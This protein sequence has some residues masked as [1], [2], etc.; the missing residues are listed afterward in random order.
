MI[1]AFIL[2]FT[3]A[4]AS[5]WLVIST[6][7]G[8]CRTRWSQVV[9]TVLL[10]AG[11]MLTMCIRMVQPQAVGTHVAAVGVVAMI[12]GA[13][14]LL[15]AFSSSWIGTV[16]DQLLIALIVGVSVRLALAWTGADRIGPEVGAEVMIATGVLWTALMLRHQGL[17]WRGSSPSLSL[18]IRAWGWIMLA[19]EAMLLL[20][21][22]T[23]APIVLN[24][25]QATLVA[26]SVT[27]TVAAIRYRISSE[28]Q[29]RKVQTA[30]ARPR[31]L[32]YWLGLPTAT[33]VL[34]TS[35]TE[36]SLIEDTTW[37]LL[38]L[39]LAA[40]LVRQVVA[41][42]DY[43]ELTG[44]LEHQKAHFKSLVQNSTD[45]IIMADRHT[46]AAVYVSPAASTILGREASTLVG[47]PLHELTGTALEEMR[48]ALNALVDEDSSVHCHGHVAG[49][50][51]ETVFSLSDNNVLATVRDVTERDQL[52]GELH[53]L[54]YV[55][56]LTGLANRHGFM[57]TL[58]EWLSNP[59]YDVSLLFVDLDRFKQVNDTGGHD[60]GDLV[61]KDVANR[62]RD[63]GGHNVTW[64][65][66]GGDEFVA[67]VIKPAPEADVEDLGPLNLGETDLPEELLGPE[68]KPGPLSA[69][70]VEML[71]APFDLGDRQ[72]QLG[73]S[74]GVA[75]AERGMPATELVRQA[76]IA[77]YAAKR[78]KTA[79]AVYEPS[80][81]AQLHPEA[82]HDVMVAR[83]LRD[84]RFVLYGQPI[85]SLLSN[86]LVNVEGLLRWIDTSGKHRPPMDIL[87]FADRTGQMSVITEWVLDRSLSVLQSS[88]TSAGCAINLTS[89][90]LNSPTLVPRLMDKL[91]QYG[92]EPHRLTI[93]VTE[94]EAVGQHNR[95]VATLS[96][97]KTAG[98]R[99]LID[100]FGAGY[101][102]L[103]YLIHLPISGLKLDRSFVS[104]LPRRPAARSIVES[105]L[106][107][108]HQNDFVLI[109]EGVETQAE[110]DWVTSLGC[111]LGQGYFYGKPKDI[112]GMPADA[113]VD[114]WLPAASTKTSE[115]TP[116]EHTVVQPKP[117]IS[118]SSD[119]NS[120]AGSPASANQP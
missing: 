71:A 99:I 88:S 7:H 105:L 62:L 97:L 72:Y 38:G 49:R 39:F 119:G 35:M 65:R 109:A 2:V 102:S 81:S 54:A 86:K 79:I 58:S 59:H 14:F 27:M 57:A 45:M 6:Q 37:A 16:L 11:G 94:H 28:L 47:R 66:L 4:T 33:A 84:R 80:M 1:A 19:E 68:S 21:V 91:Q 42:H 101:S 22:L 78:Q 18:V 34:L 87:E 108:A 25:S 26:S 52:R 114:W 77:M 69:A 111:S 63:L 83:A 98:V 96:A 95:A 60:L 56:Q 46:H 17:A 36:R 20:Y 5:I 31:T 23:G 44:D 10:C 9:A 40:L 85:V 110:H 92:V 76:D 118:K 51:T 8:A 61:L 89:Q 30:P 29:A 82:G 43:E 12:G 100:D 116:P 13:I 50:M 73:G 93:E 90:D 117:G 53:Q 67:L 112:D 103:D 107:I 64:G 70:I 104:A 48:A 75:H 115:T 74:V 32:P 55:D 113:T 106:S 41:T 24:F 3:A 120:P 15:A